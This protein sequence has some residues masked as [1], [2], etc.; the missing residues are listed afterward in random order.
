MIMKMLVGAAMAVFAYVAGTATA[1]GEPNPVN[2]G[3][4]PFSA[5]SCSCHEATPFSSAREEIDRG[6]RDGLHASLPGQP[7]PAARAS[8]AAI[9]WSQNAL[10][11]RV[12]ARG[13]GPPGRCNPLCHLGFTSH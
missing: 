3:P 11:A 6:I 9:H 12:R 13:S 5:L 8:A 10:G 7:A 1:G 2:T 4:N